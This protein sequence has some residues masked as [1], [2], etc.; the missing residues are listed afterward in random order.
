MKIEF[1]QMNLENLD[2]DLLH[3]W[4]EEPFIQEWFEQRRERFENEGYNNW[5]NMIRN[6]P[7]YHIILYLIDNNKPNHSIPSPLAQFFQ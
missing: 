6:N 5:I 3:K 4:T 1:V 2:V 7:N